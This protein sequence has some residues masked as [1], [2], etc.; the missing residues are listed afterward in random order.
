VNEETLRAKIARQQRQIELL[1]AMIEDRARDMFHVNEE[2]KLA[3]ERLRESLLGQQQ[4][5]RALVDTSRKAGMAEVATNVLHNVGNVLN[6]VN[7]SAGVVARLARGSRGG[8][9]RKAIALLREQP[10]Q[11]AFLTGDPRGRMLVDYLDGVGRALEEERESSLA[12]LGTLE[13]NIEHIKAIVSMQQSHAR[14]GGAVEEVSL[15]AIVDDALVFTSPSFERHGVVARRDL[16]DLDA[17][18][19]RIVVDRHALFEIVINLVTN[20]GQAVKELAGERL[21]TV[22]VRRV[23]PGHVA[24]A[25]EDNGVGIAAEHLTRIFGHGFTTKPDGHGFGLHSSALA[26]RDLGG[27]VQVE[28][29]GPGRGATFTLV[30]PVAPTRRSLR[31]RD[32]L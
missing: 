19:D 10:D 9:V 2:L 8:G 31:P 1:E 7:V 13:R 24:I 32:T 25:V 15:T 21:V 12:E 27:R 14:A 23:D 6:S 11:A 26:A 17:L 28:S 4:M 29:A 16:G 18:G 30:V 20:A 22:R 3:N 5:Q